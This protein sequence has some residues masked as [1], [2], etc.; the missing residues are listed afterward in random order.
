MRGRGRARPL[1]R[2]NAAAD[3][4]VCFP[5]RAHLTLMPKPICSPARGAIDQSSRRHHP[6]A[7]NRGQSSPLFRSKS[8][9]PAAEIAEPTSPKVTCAGQVKIKSKQGSCTKNWQSVMEEI[10]KI[11]GGKKARKGSS[12]WI[13]GFGFKKDVINF[14]ACLRGLRFNMRCFSSFPGAVGDSDSSVDEEEEEGEDG[15]EDYLHQNQEDAVEHQPGDHS[16]AVFSK[17]LMI[18]QENQ[19]KGAAKD[20]EGEVG[21]G[22]CTEG[23]FP[24][25]NALLLMRCRSA[26]AK[27]WLEEKQEEEDEEVKGEE[28]KKQQMVA[29][30]EDKDEKEN[31]ILK[32]YAP[33]FVKMSTDIVK[34]TWV[35][36]RSDPFSRSRSWK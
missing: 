7:A 26:P 17:W 20:E 18:L 28:E 1:P 22:S 8:R 12:N 23:S 3:L 11:H 6:K 27:T 5:P 33:D 4:L 15:H 19:H 31:F 32:N 24:P 36:G 13:H 9:P 2:G 14:M 10:E 29:L 34:E 16:R 21:S 30:K 35:V 25:K